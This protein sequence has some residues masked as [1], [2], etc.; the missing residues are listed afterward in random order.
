MEVS[1]N[2]AK[3]KHVVK[4]TK[5]ANLEDIEVLILPIKENGL[6][7]GE[8]GSISLNIKAYELKDPRSEGRKVTTHIL[9]QSLEKDKYAS[10]TEEEKRE[11]PIIGNLFQWEGDYT[12]E[13]SQSKDIDVSIDIDNDM[14]LPF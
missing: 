1:V 6:Y 7:K 14:P 3:L 10:M 4:T 12:S 13:A 5:N 9:K 8:K 2:L 11:R